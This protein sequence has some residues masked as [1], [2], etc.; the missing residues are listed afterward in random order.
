MIYEKALKERERLETK[1]AEINI[2]LEDLP[3]GKLIITRN[4]KRYKW[5]RSDGHL[6][7]YISKK[8]R[9]LA[10]RLAIRKYLSYKLN[11]LKH[12]KKAIEFYLRHH[13][14]NLSEAEQMLNASSEYRELLL[15]Y[16]KPLSEELVEWQNAFYNSNLKYPEQLLHKASGGKLVR[17]KSELL[18]DNALYTNQIPFRYECELQLGASVIYPDFTIRHPKNGDVYY[19][20]HFGKMDDANYCKNT[21][22][23]LQLYTLH[24]IIPGINLITTYETQKNPLSI[25]MVDDIIGRYFL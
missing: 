23:K 10:E 18:I 11:E 16:F 8:E 19:W 14:N 1:M 15:P 24:G 13:N 7:E 22:S 4:G 6:Q 5:Y 3:E 2:L 20:E 21:C 12:E 25:E 17:S 9:G